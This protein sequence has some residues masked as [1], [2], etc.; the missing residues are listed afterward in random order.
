MSGSAHVERD[1]RKVENSY[2]TTSHNDFKYSNKMLT[3][4]LFVATTVSVRSVA[5]STS[6][7]LIPYRNRIHEKHAAKLKACG[8][9]MPAIQI[10]AISKAT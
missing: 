5:I 2:V 4:V 7:C 3:Q 9:P 1:P 6:V 10:I 8:R